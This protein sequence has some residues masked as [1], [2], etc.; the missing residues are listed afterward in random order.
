MIDQ[1]YMQIALDL[2]RKGIGKTS[3]NPAVGC[4]IVS[5]EE[6]IAE[7]WHKRCGG[8][9]AERFALRQAGE[10]ARG[11]VMYVTLEPCSHQGRTAPCVD[12]IIA[13]GIRRVVIAMKDPNP[14][15][16]GR[17]I[18]KMRWAG[19][20]VYVGCLEKEAKEINRPFCKYITSGIPFVTVKTAQTLDGK[21][22]TVSGQ[23]RWISS[24]RMRRHTHQLRNHYDAILVGIN[25]VLKDNPALN[26]TARSKPWT[27][28]VLDSR[29][30]IPDNAKLFRDFSMIVVTTASA[31]KARIARLRKRGVDVLVCPARR[32]HI[33]WKTLL[34]E[35]GKRG[36]TNILIE[37]GAKTIG[38][39]LKERCVD[40]MVTVISPK[41]IGDQSALSAVDG[42]KTRNVNTAVRLEVDRLQQVGSDW[43][44]EG[45]VKY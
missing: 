34:K 7:G 1:H 29:L 20:D 23:S 24:A 12:Q 17:S 9:H 41:I 25:T 45:R 3:P 8:P 43:I 16:C 26:P 27:K 32:G 22:A 6:V 35:F 40:R 2:A 13:S 11:A 5:G 4:V 19:I 39:A 37:G 15:V 31:G 36:V 33:S 38:H 28:I 30:R 44:F 21:I 10:K 18:R 14:L 42:L